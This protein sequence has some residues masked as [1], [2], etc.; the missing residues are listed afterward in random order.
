MTN[1]YTNNPNTVGVKPIDKCGKFVDVYSEGFGLSQN[2]LA[3]VDSEFVGGGADD[4]ACQ[5][6][7]GRNE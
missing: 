2:G 1:C 7:L 5:V 3:V 6:G 4:R